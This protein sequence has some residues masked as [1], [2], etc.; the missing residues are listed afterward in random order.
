M[1][2]TPFELGNVRPPSGAGVADDACAAD[3]TASNAAVTNVTPESNRRDAPVFRR[4]DERRSRP[5]VVRVVEIEARK[6]VFERI[7]RGSLLRPEHFHKE[8]RDRRHVG[9]FES[10]DGTHDR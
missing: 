2:M 1:R 10:A 6:I 4:S 8:V 9:V 7:R 3:I 5:P